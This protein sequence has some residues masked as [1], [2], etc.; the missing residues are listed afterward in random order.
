M[1]LSYGFALRPTDDSADFSNALHA[2]VGNGIAPQGARFSLAVNGF[3]AKV[4]SGYGFTVGRWIKNDEPFALTLQPAGNSTDRT[5]AIAARVDYEG[6]KVVL[7]VLTDVDPTALSAEPG[8]IVLYLIR[9]RRGATSLSQSD[10]TDVRASKTLCGA[11]VPLSAV[12]RDVLMVHQFLNGGIDA[13]VARLIGLSEQVVQKA[14][15]EISRLDTAIK[16]AGGGA[17]IG[18][19][20]TSR[21]PPSE[22]GWLLCDGGNVPSGYAALSALLGGTLPDIPGERYKT[23]IFG[24]APVEMRR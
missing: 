13:E 4:A 23:Y 9:V 18:E 21:H 12:S 8:L 1:S 7:E 10:I 11:V 6:R 5:D 16:Q 3:T 14:D 17:E 20:M 15:A 24:G 22:T 2:V 19:L